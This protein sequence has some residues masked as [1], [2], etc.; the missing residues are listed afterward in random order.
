MQPLSDIEMGLMDLPVKYRRRFYL[1]I[2]TQHR[3]WIWYIKVGKNPFHV[4]PIGTV[5]DRR[6]PIHW[7]AAFIALSRSRGIR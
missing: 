3:I 5:F 7:V 4:Q 6:K 1:D 2:D